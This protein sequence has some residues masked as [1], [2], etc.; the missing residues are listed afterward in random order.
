MQLFVRADFRFAVLRLARGIWLF[1][2]L[3]A[4]SCTLIRP[5]PAGIGAA[6]DWNALPGWQADSLAAAWPALLNGCTRLPARK[7]EWRS[8]CSAAARLDRPSDQQVRAFLEHHFTPHRINGPKGRREGLI[9]GYYEPLL[10]GNLTR[11]DRY[12]FPVYGRP[13][14][15]LTVDLGALYPPLKG[16]RVRG[17][18]DGRRVVPF[19]PRSAI[20]QTPSP[21]KGNEILWVDNRDDLFFLQVQGSGR[22]ELPDGRIVGLV[23]ADQNGQP[24]VSIGRRLVQMNEIP[25]DEV[26]LTT[27]RAW[28][29]AHPARATAL[30]NENPSYVF[31]ALRE[32]PGDGPV[33]SLNVP[34]TP[35]RSVAVDPKVVPLG[36]P[37][38]LV[39]TLPG[40]PATDFRH[41]VFAQ[42]TGGAIKG[43]LRADLFFGHG[44]QAERLAGEMKQSGIAFALLPNN[45]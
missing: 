5:P 35:Q 43:A 44:P 11:S 9:T 38:W 37:L 26:S 34:L 4:A 20:D 33:G 7:A 30:L 1:A 25:L 27:L 6:V 15:L 3:A 31:F 8:I 36:T 12:R 10:H 14:S 18:L 24:Y 40:D 28:L 29:D 32:T 45:H 19:Y 17:R 2:A 42:D 16:K 13:D 21:L 41:L 39:T 22:V 23:Y